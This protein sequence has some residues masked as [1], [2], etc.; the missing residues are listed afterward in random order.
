M[1]QGN[2][3]A[4][5]VVPKLPD[6]GDHA[7][8]LRGEGSTAATNSLLIQVASFYCALLESINQTQQAASR[9]EARGDEGAGEVVRAVAEL[10]HLAGGHLVGRPRVTLVDLYSCF[11][12]VP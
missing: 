9:L 1:A 10:L 6:D 11:R 12:L 3:L 7:L 5:T 2:I 8:L 4:S